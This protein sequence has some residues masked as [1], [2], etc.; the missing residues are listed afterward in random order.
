MR[1]EQY[2]LMTD[3]SLWEVILNRDSP[4][5][6]RIVEGVVQPVAPITAEQNLARKNELKTHTLIWRNKTDLEDKSLDDLFNSLKIYKTEVK[7]SS[8]ISTES[9]NLAFESSSQTDSTTDS[10]SAVVYICAVGSTLPASPLLNHYEKPQSISNTC[11][12]EKVDSNVIP[13]SPDMCDNDIQTDLN[14]VECDDERVAL[15]N[16]I[17]N[18]KLDTGLEMYKT[19]NDRTV[20]YDKLE[21]RELVDQAWEKYSHDYFCAPTAHD[22]EILIK[23][24]LM[25]LALKTQNDSFTFVHELKKYMHADLKYV[26]SLEKEVDELESDKADFLNMYDILISI[27]KNTKCFNVA[28]EELSAIK[29]KLMLLDTAAERRL[30]LLKRDFVKRISLELNDDLERE[31]SNAKIKRAVWDYGIDKA[32]RPDGFTFGFYRRYWDIIGNDVVDDV[33]WFLLH[34]E[35]PKEGNSSFITLI[36]KVPNANMVKDFRP[37]SLIENLYKVIAKILTNRLV[38]VFDDII[39][40][41]QS[42]FVM[43]RQILDG[44]LILNEIVH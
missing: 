2:F 36:L 14:A 11:I 20:D 29:H 30:M 28:G 1:I 8:F 24:C 7:H 9:H 40:E 4:V 19:L 35:I 25:P 5:P 18:L 10:V 27:K 41:I 26:E 31:V 44:P 13:D 32:A 42:A 21:C 34:G 39:D 43:D 33:K 23:T 16:L 38:T 22:I 3:Y 12:V 15:A 37:I 6:T 17:T